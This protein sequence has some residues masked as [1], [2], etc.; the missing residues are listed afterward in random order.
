MLDELTALEM[1]D[2]GCMPLSSYLSL[3]PVPARAKHP[4][5]APDLPQGRPA[6]NLGVARPRHGQKAPPPAKSSKVPRRAA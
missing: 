1:V 2:A 4:R 6:A 3:F 5:L